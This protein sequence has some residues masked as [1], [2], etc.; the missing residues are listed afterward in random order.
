MAYVT[1]IAVVSVPDIE[2]PTEERSCEGMLELG[3]RRFRDEREVQ[4]IVATNGITDV[5]LDAGA[6][7]SVWPMEDEEQRSSISIDLA[8]ADLIWRA[9]GIAKNTFNDR[10]FTPSGSNATTQQIIDDVVT[11]A[12]QVLNTPDPSSPWAAFTATREEVLE[13]WLQRSLEGW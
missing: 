11:T 5:A 13:V 8:K 1:I 9:I 12:L 6:D 7:P 10:T 2:L 3:M 4:F